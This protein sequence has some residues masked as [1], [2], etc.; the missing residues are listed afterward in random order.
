MSRDGRIPIVMDVDTGID[1]AFALLFAARYPGLE[2]LGVT[3]VDGN[4]DVNTVVRNTLTVLDAAGAQHVPVAAGAQRPLL[5]EPHYSPAVHGTDGLADLGLP[6][7]ARACRPE[8]AVEFLRDTILGSSRPIVL[9]AT[10]PLTNIALLFRT[11]PEVAA[12]IS[13][14]VVMAG[15]GGAGNATALAEFNAWHDPEAA[16]IVFGFE[17]PLT[18]YGLDVFYDLELSRQHIAELSKS[19]AGAAQFATRLAGGHLDSLAARGLPDDATTLG[20]YGVVAVL[21]E[22]AGARI[23]SLP[24]LVTTAPGPGR[25]QT[26]LDRRPRPEFAEGDASLVGGRI[27]DVVTWIDANRYRRLWLD[28]VSND[29]PTRLQGTSARSSS[30]A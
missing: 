2:L 12:N 17:V 14:V 28:A 16:A 13:R 9:A 10:A 27:I 8:H 15:S 22:P 21:A 29:C 30:S 25:G 6:R 3:C 26:I 18:M 1:D 19:T 23:E 4:T 11:Y 24:A 7:S 5:A 20:D